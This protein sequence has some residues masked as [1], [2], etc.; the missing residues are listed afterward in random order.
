LRSCRIATKRTDSSDVVEAS[1]L[2]PV[3]ASLGPH[4]VYVIPRGAQ[5]LADPASGFG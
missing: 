5:R 2:R 4:K 1:G 3:D